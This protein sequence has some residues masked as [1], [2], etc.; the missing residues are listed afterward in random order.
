ME[1]WNNKDKKETQIH[2]QRHELDYD[3]FIYNF[4]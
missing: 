4:K 3:F 2:L 1:H